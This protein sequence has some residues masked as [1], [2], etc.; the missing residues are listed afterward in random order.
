MHAGFSSITVARD[1]PAGRNGGVPGLSFDGL[2]LPD[3]TFIPVRFHKY[4]TYGI[5]ATSRF[6][7]QTGIYGPIVVE[8]ALR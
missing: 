5:T 3:Y 4:G 7:K 2:S 1:H 8:A 6:R